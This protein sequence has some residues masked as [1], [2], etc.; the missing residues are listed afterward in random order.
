[1]HH[2]NYVKNE[3]RETK[4]KMKSHERSYLQDSIKLPNI[5]DA[6]IQPLFKFPEELEDVSLRKKLKLK[7]N[8][9]GSVKEKENKI[10]SKHS[11]TEQRLKK[12]QFRRQLIEL[13]V[14]P[15]LS[16][17]RLDSRDKDINR[18]Y[19]YVQNGINTVHV[20]TLEKRIIDNIMIL[21]SPQFRNRFNE[22][23]NTLLKEVENEFIVSMK[24]SIVEFAFKDPFENEFSQVFRIFNS[25]IY[26]QY[27]WNF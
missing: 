24:K 9:A 19:Y 11:Y 5:I 2:Y 6:K 16:E 3:K 1:M 21:I 18:Y 12:E 13:I 22:F 14:K 17:E 25:F 27:L 26:G 4:R 8:G 10:L 15:E 23:L 20:T 7:N